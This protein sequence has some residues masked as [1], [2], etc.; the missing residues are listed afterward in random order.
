M[1]TNIRIYLVTSLSVLLK[2]E[3]FQTKFIEKIETHI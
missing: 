1:K 3:M 2:K